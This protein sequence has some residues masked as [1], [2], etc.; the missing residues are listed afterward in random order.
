LLL[1]FGV[2]A[3]P[4]MLQVQTWCMMV[5]ANQSHGS[6]GVAEVHLD[7]KP[8]DTGTAHIKRSHCEDG[9]GSVAASMSM[10]DSNLGCCCSIQ[11]ANWVATR[12]DLNSESLLRAG[13]TL[14]FDQDS[15]GGRTEHTSRLC[16]HPSKTQASPARTPV[17]RQAQL[18]TFLI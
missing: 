18:S 8:A 13:V 7:Y 12:V 4:A 14:D 1:S 16:L 15:L 5:Q 17:A 3:T 2:L 9:N 6:V 10:T 11:A